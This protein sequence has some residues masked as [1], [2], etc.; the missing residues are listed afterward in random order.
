MSTLLNI[1][2]YPLSNLT[3]PFPFLTVQPEAWLIHSCLKFLRRPRVLRVFSCAEACTCK[4]PFARASNRC[5]HVQGSPFARAKEML[6][7][8]IARAKDMVAHA[9]R[10]ICTCK[11]FCHV[12]RK[13]LFFCAMETIERILKQFQCN[14]LA[15]DTWKLCLRSLCVSIQHVQTYIYAKHIWNRFNAALAVNVQT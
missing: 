3:Y 7:V 4:H 11:I 12:S 10:E 15:P 1:L 13:E 5:L 9:G 2:S 14:D 6:H 8:Q